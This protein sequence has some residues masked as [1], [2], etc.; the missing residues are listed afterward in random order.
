MELELQPAVKAALAMAC[1]AGAILLTMLL[2]APHK[3]PPRNCTSTELGCRAPQVTLEDYQLQ[4]PVRISDI[5]KRPTIF[6]LSSATCPVFVA[7]IP[8]IHNLYDEVKNHVNVLVVYVHEQHPRP[9]SPYLAQQTTSMRREAAQSLVAS[10]GL[11]VPMLIDRSDDAMSQ[12]Y[13]ASGVGVFMVDD[14]GAI[15]YNDPNS[16]MNGFKELRK[17]IKKKGL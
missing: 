16:V 8:S 13:P 10:T 9:Y 5:T 3:E 12:S 1:L 2:F 15:L 6:I 14:N 17:L 4:R 7:H 11:R